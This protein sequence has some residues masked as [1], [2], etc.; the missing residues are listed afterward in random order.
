MELAS[1]LVVA[2]QSNDGKTIGL[3]LGNALAGV[4][5][6]HIQQDNANTN[7]IKKPIVK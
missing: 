3:D 6:V 7:T 2:A 4:Y 5:F 1:R